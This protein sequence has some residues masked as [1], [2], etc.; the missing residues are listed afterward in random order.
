MKSI[1]VLG[2]VIVALFTM[3]FSSANMQA[4]ETTEPAAT[5]PAVEETVEGEY[6]ELYATLT[7]VVSWAGGFSGLMALALYAVRSFVVRKA[8]TKADEFM[9]LLKESD[10]DKS[11]KL[12]QLYEANIKAMNRQEELEKAIINLV[13]MSNM[14]PKLRKEVISSI[15]DPETSVSDLLNAKIELATEEIAQSEQT[16]LEVKQKTES[17]LSKL[18]EEENSE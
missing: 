12:E 3:G 17:L 10:K 18:A 2:L 14:D 4:A 8:N 7:A 1:K 16:Q 9:A 11:K 5:E 15:E 6:D 13:S